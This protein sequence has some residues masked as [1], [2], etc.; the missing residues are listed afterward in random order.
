[1]KNSLNDNFIECFSERLNYLIDESDIN[2]K[3]L[4]EIIGTSE[5]LI[6]GYKKGKIKPGIENIIKIAQYFNCDIHW[7]ITGKSHE[8]EKS[9]IAEEN[10]TY[11]TNKKLNNRIKLPNGII[12]DERR[13]IF[14]QPYIVEICQIILRFDDDIKG[15]IYKA[16]KIFEE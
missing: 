13:E 12:I 6:T 1:M 3:K 11:K 9:K 5:S 10:I 16:I 8:E 2:Q 14:K 4:A 15:R 7:L